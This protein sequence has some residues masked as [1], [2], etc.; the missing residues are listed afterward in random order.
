MRVWVVED[1]GRIVGFA[2]TSPS[3][4]SDASLDTAELGAI[5]LD[6]S[7][8]GRGIG[9]ALLTRAMRD[10]REWGFRRATLWVLATNAR[11]RRFYEIAGWRPDGTEKAETL[12]GFE[13]REVRYAI[14]LQDAEPY[15]PK[16]S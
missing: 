11:A 5:Y 12:G 8:V 6:Q 16:Q 10:L 3:R 14:D 7:V 2:S 13:A 9:R 4:D 15:A 1:D